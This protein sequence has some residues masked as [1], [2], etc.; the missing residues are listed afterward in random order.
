MSYKSN[1]WKMYLFKFLLQMHFFG[2]VLIPFF[3]DWGGITFTQVMVLESIYVLAIVFLEIPTGAVADFLGRKTSLT[4][5]A[6]TMIVAAIVYSLTPSFMLFVIAEIIWAIGHTLLSGADQAMIYDSLKTMKSEKQSKK[7]FGRF[8]SFPL[9]AIIVAAPLGSLIAATLGLRYTMLLMT[10]PFLG[11]FIISLTLKEPP[12]EKKKKKLSYLKTV[13]EGVNYFKKHK[14]LRILAFDKISVAALVFFI[15]WLYQPL[16][17]LFNIPIAYFGLMLGAMAAVQAITLNSF[18]SLE[19]VFKSKKNYLFWS[20]IVSGVAF[21]L[22]GFNN[23]IVFALVLILVASAFG[24]S[25]YVLLNNYMNKHIDSH[26]RA[27]VL[28][29]VSMVDRLF[30]AILY[31]IVGLLVEWSLFITFIIIGVAIIAS[32]AFSRVEEGHLVD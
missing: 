15:I 9:L 7:I 30:R 3:T 13:T 17:T 26:N 10:I 27:T 5:S 14:T 11:A 19:R 23:S 24:L 6:V 8:E 32:T 25:R 16:F 22:L 28:S 12:A 21:I 18:S 1:L 29:S 2:G 4:L 31:P 20:A